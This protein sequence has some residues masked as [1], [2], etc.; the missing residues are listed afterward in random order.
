MN[1][2]WIVI[3]LGLVGALARTIGWSFRRHR[4]TD[5]GLVS[6][7]WIAEHRISQEQ[8]RLR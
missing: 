7:Q 1:A 2:L 3:G 6:H 8:D 5:L 4:P